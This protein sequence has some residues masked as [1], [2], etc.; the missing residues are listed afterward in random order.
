[1]KTISTDTALAMH[2]LLVQHSRTEKHIG[3]HILPERLNALVTGTPHQNRYTFREPER[4]AFFREHVEFEGRTVLDIGCNI[5][6]FLFSLLDL[7]A[8]RVIGYEGKPSCCRYLQQAIQALGEDDRF[9]LHDEYFRFDA[10][11]ERSD[12]AL[13]LNVL[14]HL[15][16][17][18]GSKD[19][20]VDA[21]RQGM[22][23]QLNGLSHSA[24]TL[25]FQMGFNWKGDRH[26][27]LFKHGTKAEMI[28]FIAQGTAADWSI[29]AIGIPQRVDGG[30]RYMAPSPDNI[31]RD[32]A[33]G[34]FL[35]RPLFILRSRHAVQGGLGQA[36][37]RAKP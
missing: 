1:M 34:E 7:G 25:V 30:V 29:D 21:A 28:D 16:D 4:L 5:G 32:D 14:H 24:S 37:A 35:N 17:D 2:A 15:G 18:Y 33:L 10:V 23:R 20:S 3:Y 9:E 6:Y 11:A 31:A 36:D 27:C 26:A 19:L 8:K 12:V 13:L 22:L